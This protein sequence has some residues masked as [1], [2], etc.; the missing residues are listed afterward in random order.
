MYVQLAYA[1]GR[2][3]PVSATALIDGASED[4]DIYDER[5]T[6]EGIIATLDLRNPIYEATSRYGHFGRGF[7]W[8]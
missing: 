6:P 4:L 5:L 7:I 2:S 8:G 3:A 1:I